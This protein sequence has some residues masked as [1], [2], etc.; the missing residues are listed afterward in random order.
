MLKLLKKALVII[1]EDITACPSISETHAAIAKHCESNGYSCDFVGDNEVVIGGIV[2]E[3]ICARS[4]FYQ[5]RYVI[6]C[7]EK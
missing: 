3:I 5:G 7:R 2:H 1:W 6:K 4:A